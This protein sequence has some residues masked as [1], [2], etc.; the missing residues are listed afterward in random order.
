MKFAYPDLPRIQGKKPDSNEEVWVA[1]ALDR[2]KIPYIFQ[3]ELEP[4]ALRGGIKID[5]LVLAPYLMPIEIMGEYWHIGELDPHERLRQII[6]EQKLG[7]PVIYLWTKDLIDPDTTY[8]VVR[9][10][11][12]V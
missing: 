6:I 3:F 7:Q 2:L 8:T 10:K 1:M 12:R 11:V 9:Q 5:F 4:Q